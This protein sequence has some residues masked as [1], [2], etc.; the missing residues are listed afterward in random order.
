MHM[1]HVEPELLFQLF[2]RVHRLLP[3]LPEVPAL[4]QV[5][6]G[7]SFTQVESVQLPRAKYAFDASKILDELQLPNW[8]ASGEH[9]ALCQATKGIISLCF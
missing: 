9:P 7:V 3:H 4:P 6:S 5:S 1:L 8:L 2:E